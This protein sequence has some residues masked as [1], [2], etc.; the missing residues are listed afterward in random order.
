MTMGPISRGSIT[1]KSGRA[2]SP[3]EPL[4]KCWFSSITL[5][6]L[7]CS[8]TALQAESIPEDLIGDWSLYLSSGEAGWISIEEVND[9][10]TVCMAV[11]TGST[12]PHKEVK[13][14]DG[15]VK[16]RL[17]TTRDGR[18]GPI[19]LTDDVDFWFNGE[20]LQGHVH[21]IH[22]NGKESWDYFKGKKLPPMPPAPD[23]AKVKFGEAIQLFNGKDL[24]GWKLR[25]P[26]KKNGWS[27]KDGLM[28]NET[29]K[30]DFSA[31]GAYSNLMTE[32]VFD[33]FKLHIEFQIGSDRNSGVYLRG[34]YEAQ[35]VDR[36]SRM[37]GLQGVGAI[38]G[39]VAPSENAG[40]EGGK[41]QTYVL[42]LV[43]RH[44]TVVLNGVKV[45]NNQPVQLPTG[46]AM[47]T[48]PTEPGPIYLQGDHTSVKYR[49]IV[50]AK[51]LK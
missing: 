7:I 11:D 51:R 22:A 17:R 38:F 23:L 34:M 39:R 48:D 47:H 42:T 16:F 37:Q 50:L 27:V 31:T 35:V 44:L 43:D 3:S 4:L 15:H 33:D 5:L 41:W 45:I 49:N 1:L 26:W 21:R 19:L 40:Y 18:G 46:G 36:E 12:R 30:T 10:H 28:V 8:A 25:R 20:T 24:S 13:V 14:E 9:E 29:P 2:R 6:T 32:E